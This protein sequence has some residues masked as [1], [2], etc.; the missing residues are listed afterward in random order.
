MC[1]LFQVI[2]HDHDLF[3]DTQVVAINFL[4]RPKLGLKVTTAASTLNLR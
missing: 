1:D 3:E 2:L 4:A